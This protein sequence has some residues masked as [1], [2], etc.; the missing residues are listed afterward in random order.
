MFAISGASRHLSNALHVWRG[1]FNAT[2]IK[3]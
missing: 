1:S 2:L 3:T